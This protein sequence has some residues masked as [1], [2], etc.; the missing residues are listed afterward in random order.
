MICRYCPGISGPPPG[1]VDDLRHALDVLDRQLRVHRQRQ[2]PAGQ[3]FG[4]RQRADPEAEVG[5]G[6]LQVARQRI[7]DVRPDAGRV[8]RGLQLVAAVYLDD[9]QVVDRLGP[10]RVA[11]TAIPFSASS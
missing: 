5:A 10:G 1:G 2:H 11:G 7:V 6:R 9:V 3:R 4:D 8:Q